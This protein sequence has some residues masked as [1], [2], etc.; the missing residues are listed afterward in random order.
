MKCL[1][2]ILSVFL[3][4]SSYS[5]ITALS[6]HPIPVGRSV[7]IKIIAQTD[8]SVFFVGKKI[9]EKGIW[10]LYISKRSA[11][12]NKIDFEVCLDV[13]KIYNGSFNIDNINFE[14]MHC[15]N[16]IIF[17]FTAVSPSNKILFA[18]IVSYEG[19]VS[20]TVVVDRTDYTNENLESC[21]YSY[22]LTSKKNILIFNQ[23][24]Y[25]SG[26]RR[27]KCILI[28]NFLN[29]IWEQDLPTINAHNQENLIADVDNANNLI[30]YNLFYDVYTYLNTSN[31]LVSQKVYNYASNNVKIKYEL[32]KL[33]Y[34]LLIRQDS[35]QLFFLNGFK[36]EITSKK[37]YYPFLQFPTI[38]SIS[39][40]QLLMYN[41]V[42]IDDEKYI[43]PGKKGM[44]YKRFDLKNDATLLDTLVVLSDKLQR[45]LS[46]NYGPGGKRPTGKYF[47]LMNE[48]FV[49]GKL[50]SLFEHVFNGQF[51]E[52]M[53]CS[54]N[55]TVNKFEWVELLPRKINIYY[56]NIYDVVTRYYDSKLSVS[57]Y[58]HPKNTLVNNDYNDFDA[59]KLLRKP[60]DKMFASYTFF[61]SGEV[62]KQTFQKID[63]SFMFPWLSGKKEVDRNYFFSK[64]DF[65]PIEFL[66]K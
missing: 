55:V 61:P 37:L 54:Y 45:K 14:Y 46:Y 63:D 9:A 3:F 36:K 13:R 62:K 40:T 26:F 48:N 1:A 65:L 25:T 8:S 58:E 59:Y 57:F 23:R 5:Q 35:I 47:K 33:E 19:E 6:T 11:F 20:E 64:R 29:K 12:Q 18:K 24:D 60:Q 7:P 50:I 44:Y 38:K 32:G 53:A 34:D 43:F 16:N 51:L 4:Q 39:S 10:D 22:F 42:D 41:V 31:K 28:D 52:I 15:K 21:S 27:D 2:F 56:P 66:Y 49:E 30:F 17:L